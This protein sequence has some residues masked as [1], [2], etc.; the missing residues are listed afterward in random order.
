[1]LFCFVFCNSVQEQI[2]NHW[3]RVFT[4]SYLSSLLN[5]YL[6][7]FHLLLTARQKWRN[8]GSFLVKNVD[9]IENN[10][11]GGMVRKSRFMIFWLFSMLLHV[12]WSVEFDFPFTFD[13]QT[14]LTE[15]WQFFRVKRLTTLK[16]TWIGAVYSQ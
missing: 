11:N 7:I 5:M 3:F 4:R 16:I 13:G 15:L 9:I 14:K 8:Y 2:G 1:M 10:I 12:K 6:G